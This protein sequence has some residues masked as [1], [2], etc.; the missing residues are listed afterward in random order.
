MDN[1]NVVVGKI[2][3]AVSGSMFL[4]IIIKV[5]G[6]VKQATIAAVYGSTF[7]TDIFFMASEFLNNI[8][9]ALFSSL[10]IV[11]VPLYLKKK[12]AGD[13]L[14]EYVTKLL[15]SF[16]VVAIAIMILFELGT[17]V[18]AKVLAPSYSVIESR[19]LIVELRIM[20]PALLF[21]CLVYIFKAVLDAEKNFLPSKSIGGIQSIVIIALSVFGA[22]K[23]GITALSVGFLLA[24]VIEV[25]FLFGFVKKYYKPIKKWKLFDKDVV[26]IIKQMIPLCIGSAIADISVIVD[27]IIATGLGDGIVSALAYGQT[28]KSFVV[29]VVVTTTI[30]VVFVYLSDFVNLG[31]IEELRDLIDR[32]ICV[33]TLVLIPISIVSFL[34]AEDIVLI[35]FGRGNFD[36]TAVG[37]TANVLRGYAIGFIPLAIRSTLMKVHY[38]YSDSLNPLI[39]GIITICCNIVLSVIFSRIMGVFG[40]VI[41]TSCS[42]MVSM[43]LMFCSVRKHISDYRPTKLWCTVYKGMPAI[44][45]CLLIANLINEFSNW[46]SLVDF[47]LTAIIS[48][49]I[50]IFIL[51]ILRFEEIDYLI[52]KVRKKRRKD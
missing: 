52:L 50:Y 22:G 47:A 8:A 46:N 45:V 12:N 30:S 32:G 2:V 5:I 28:L 9:V 49:A 14:N 17:T 18:L 27:K 19:R 40:I 38:A 1:K 31:K 15:I 33:L 4:S 51:K 24:T 11:L 35:I 23:Y 43:V 34:C 42:Y 44:I 29:A 20:T 6:F 16:S 10:T 41:A 39:N 13:N 7:E 3:S 37:H 21:M 36:S 48:F 25:V 26:D